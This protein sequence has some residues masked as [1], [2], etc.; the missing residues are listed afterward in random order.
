MYYVYALW[1]QKDQKFYIGYTKDLKRRMV[2]HRSG[3]CH[4]TYR[5]REPELIFYEAYRCNSDGK[6]REKYFKTSKGKKTL[7]LMLRDTL[8]E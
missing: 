6:R 3:G 5:L 2:E 4:T 1:S 7:R 8:K